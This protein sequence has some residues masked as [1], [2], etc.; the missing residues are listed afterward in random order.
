MNNAEFEVLVHDVQESLRRISD[1]KG[2]EYASDHDRLSNFKKAAAEAGITPEQAWL[3]FFNKHADTVK[4][5]CRTGSVLSESIESRIDD[6]IVYLVLLRGLVWEK[7]PPPTGRS[8]A[9]IDP[10]EQAGRV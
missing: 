1:T 4:F 7:A 10:R 6:A 8:K 3:V 2:K 9:L 5:Y